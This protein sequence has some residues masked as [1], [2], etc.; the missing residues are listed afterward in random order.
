MTNYYL[1][2]EGFCDSQI[3]ILRN[4]VF[5]SCMKRVVCTKNFNSFRAGHNCNKQ[6]VLSVFFFFFFFFGG[7]GGGGSE[8]ISLNISCESSAKQTIHMICKVFF[9]LKNNKKIFQNAD[10]HNFANT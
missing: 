7:G 9:V 8:K 2:S 5:V 6:C 4:F 3:V 1:L 10:C